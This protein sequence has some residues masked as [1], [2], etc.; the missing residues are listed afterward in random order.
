MSQCAGY[1]CQCCLNI[2]NNN[3]VPW[4]P[5]HWSTLD[6]YQPWTFPHRYLFELALNISCFCANSRKRKTCMCMWEERE[7]WRN[8]MLSG[9]VEISMK[10]PAH[11]LKNI[12]NNLPETSNL[13]VSCYATNTLR[14]GISGAP[15]WLS[16]LCIRLQ[17]RSWSHGSWVHA[18]CQALCWL[19]R[20]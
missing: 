2:N 3:I 4:F 1:F 8:K 14:W 7:R 9:K 17:L 10:T 11:F 16:Q 19:L 13:S 20:A 15:G 12:L 6:L 18:Q 5:L